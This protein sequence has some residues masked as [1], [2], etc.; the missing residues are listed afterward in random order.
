MEQ[1]KIK[2]NLIKRLSEEYHPEGYNFNGPYTK[3]IERMS[4]NYKGNVG[5]KSYYLPSNKLDLAAFKHDLEYFSPSPIARMY[6]D[7]QYYN[8]NL[9]D[10]NIP[11]T[12]YS[13]AFIYST[14]LARI[15]KEATKLGISSLKIY[16]QI[17]ALFNLYK[18]LYIP[19]GIQQVPAGPE[20]IPTYGLKG[21]YLPTKLFGREGII[22]QPYRDN[23]KDFFYNN[24]GVKITTAR[25][26]AF[27]KRFYKPVRDLILYSLFIGSSVLPRPIPQVFKLLNE[28]FTNYKES[29][30][31]KELNNESSKVETAYKNYLNKVGYFNDSGDFVIKDKINE[32]QAKRAYI[33]YYRE[34][35]KYFNW[36]N[37]YY[38]DY[39]GF[40]E[41]VKETYP[42]D[43]K[44]KMPKLD[45]K[46]LEKVANPTMTKAPPIQ[47]P[48]E[49]KFEILDPFPTSAEIKEPEIKEPEIEEPEEEGLLE[50]EI[51]KIL[52]GQQDKPFETPAEIKYNFDNLPDFLK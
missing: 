27:N 7:N 42:N 26:G 40:K 50:D 20:Q 6:A 19:T 10:S 8:K 9:K 45:M 23:I 28:I 13:Q 1:E 52:Q 41:Y 2:L 14:W 38:K 5:T 31:Y 15:A 11:E 48:P 18:S 51:L 24:L 25:G 37:D 46:E 3:N 29:K 22:P 49:F 44:W 17:P 39:P 36:V 35:K 43:N 4:L 21:F 16:K 30:E 12:K 33:K 47:L 32:N 34:S